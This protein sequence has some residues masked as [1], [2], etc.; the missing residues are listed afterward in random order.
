MTAMAG[1]WH[2]GEERGQWPTDV[3]F[4]EYYGNLGANT[5]YHDFRDPEISPELIN[6]PALR[7]AMDQV[8][9]VRST[10]RL[11]KGDTTLTLDEEIN[12]ETEPLLEERYTAWSEDFIKRASAA[13]KPFFLYHSMNRT[14]TK[15]YPNPRFVGQ[16]PAGT[17]YKDAVLEVDWVL[18]EL[19]DTLRETGELENTLVF[20]TSDNGPEEDVM[21]NALIFTSDAGHT[22]FRGAK[23]TTLEGGVRVPGIAY[24]PG[25]I[26][27]GRVSDGLFDLM[28]LFCTSAALAEASGKLPNDRYIDGIDQTSFLL[29]DGDDAQQS[30]REAV[31]YCYGQEF[32]GTRWLEFKRVEQEM[33]VGDGT[34]RAFGGIT[35]AT[36]M[37]FSD[38]SLGWMYNLY[39]DP[40]ERIPMAKTWAVAPTV[41][42]TMH[43]KM[44]FVAYP[45]A[46]RGVHLGGY[47]LG[48][49]AGG[50]LPAD[51][52]LIPDAMGD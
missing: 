30:N 12:L 35:N 6:K 40:K 14:H 26:K 41:E 32:Y 29:T 4:D 16:S 36:R 2:L 24:W 52:R 21:A 1:K 33:Q 8:N 7:A 19:I 10:V 25:M 11:E 20:F 39:M 13:N 42:L 23:G 9:F 49:P 38:P 47:L 18:G 17:P 48:G 37:S 44:T 31:F 51:F 46:P 15:N 3:G 50:T 28:D 34:A 45:Q 22:P 43:H 27:S 5:T